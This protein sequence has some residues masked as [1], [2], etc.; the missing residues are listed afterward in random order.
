MPKIPGKDEDGNN[1]GGDALRGGRVGEF[2]QTR[3]TRIPD[4]HLNRETV[5]GIRDMNLGKVKNGKHVGAPVIRFDTGHNSGANPH[6]NIDPKGYPSRTN[7]H[8]EVPAEVINCAQKIN[9]AIKYAG[10]TLTVAAVVVDGWRIGSAFKDDLY[11]RDH[12]DE[13]I[14]ELED[15]IYELKKALRSETNSKKVKE[16]RAA[17]E[18]LEEILKDVKRTKKLNVPVKTIKTASSAAGGWGGG[19]AGGA[20]GAWGGAQAGALVGSCLGP[21][22]TVVGA[23]IGAVVGAI[24]GGTLSGMGGSFLGKWLADKALDL[25]DD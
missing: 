8:I 7:P 3:F 15:A 11:I 1:L 6:I 22:G 2:M 5:A 12:A 10:I 9:S 14:R 17:M 18:H 21:V 13:V 4:A 24:G 20:A 19:A 23:P 25:A 16:I